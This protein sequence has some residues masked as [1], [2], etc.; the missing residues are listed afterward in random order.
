MP[1]CRRLTAVVR[2]SVAA[3]ALFLCQQQLGA[4]QLTWTLRSSVGPSARY[5]HAMAYDSHRGKI[6]MFGG[7]N[8]TSF[9]NDM[10]EWD[11]ATWTRS[12][13][14]GPTGRADHAMAYDSQ[15]QRI[16]MF[17]G[18]DWNSDFNAETWECDGMAWLPQ[19]WASGPQGRNGHAMAYD[20]S[21][22]VTVMFGGDDGSSS[23]LSDIWEWNGASWSHPSA[24]GPSGTRD[25][26]MVFDPSRNVVAMFGG[27][28]PNGDDLWE[29]GG[30]NWFQRNASGPARF[31]HSMAFDA[32]NGRLVVYGGRWS[33][34]VL[35]DTIEYVG[36]AWSSAPASLVGLRQGH[37]MAYDTQR[38]KLV[39]FGGIN[40]SSY[41]SDTWERGVVTIPSSGT[42]YGTGC[43]AP[44]LALVPILNAGPII[45]TTAQVMAINIPS[46]LAFVS[47]GWSRTT[48][49]GFTLPY[50]LSAYGMGNCYLLQSADF[51]AVP[52][53]FT[54]LGSAAYNMAVPNWNAI[55]GLQLFLQAWANS[56]GSNAANAVTSNGVEWTIGNS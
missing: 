45:G 47:I 4:Q 51:P 10:W 28:G 50:Q 39:L 41:L 2:P 1:S 32:Q 25:H 6:V 14:A 18:R 20:S 42:S 44:A 48:I 26:A 24:F 33:G 37:A 17:G 29:W 36:S 56:P 43:G 16:V 13:F 49:G 15:R 7:A 3:F 8:Q 46:T 21:R 11:G 23:Y 19:L 38:S 53:T 40:A 5:G 52:M 9:L 12:P 30:L 54:G 34:T 31:E 22:G 55:L 35:D 27:M